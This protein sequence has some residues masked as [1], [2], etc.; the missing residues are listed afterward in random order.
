ML[1]LSLR[2]V[3][4][5]THSKKNPGISF[6]SHRNGIPEAGAGLHSVHTGPLPLANPRITAQYKAPRGQKGAHS[7]CLQCWGTQE[8]AISAP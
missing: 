3:M 1:L 7:A 5:H 4:H 8:P 6:S 2:A